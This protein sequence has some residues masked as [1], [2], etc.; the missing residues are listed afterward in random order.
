MSDPHIND[1]AFDSRN[2]DPLRPAKQ[3]GMTFEEHL[4]I[5]EAGIKMLNLPTSK[6]NSMDDFFIEARKR[7]QE[8]RAYAKAHYADIVDGGHM[9]DRPLFM[10]ELTAKFLQAYGHYTKDELL[11]ILSLFMAQALVVET[12]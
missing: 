8:V 3:K 12:T 7:M 1:P 6:P 5:V 9:V 10:Q 11:M 4:R 2:F